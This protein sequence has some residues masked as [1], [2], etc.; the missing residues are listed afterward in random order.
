MGLRLS[1][2]AGPF[3][4]EDGVPTG[5][6]YPR[7]VHKRALTCRILAG[8][9]LLGAAADAR[10]TGALMVIPAAVAAATALLWCARRE[11]DRPR[12]PPRWA[13]A[14]AVA[15]TSLAATAAHPVT[16]GDR[17]GLWWLVET[18]GLVALLSLTARR[19]ASWRGPT[20]QALLLTALTALPIRLGLAL[21]PPSD[22]GELTAVCLVSGLLGLAAS[23]AGGHLR[24]LDRRRTR[25]VADARRAQR[26]ALAR[27]LHDFVAHEVSGILVQAQAGLVV[28]ERDPAQA[29]AALRRIEEA[30]RR[31]MSS[32]DDAV[33]MLRDEAD[34]SVPHGRGLT[35]VTDAVRRYEER[36]PAQVALTVA[37]AVHDDPQPPPE[38]WALAHRVVV[39]ALTNVTRHAPDARRIEVEL[40]RTDGEFT[41]AVTND[42]GDGTSQL[43]SAAR[44]GGGHGVRGLRERARALGGTLTAGRVADG[45]WRLRATLPVARHAAS[46]PAVPAVPEDF[47]G[48]EARER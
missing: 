10:A 12:V 30:G 33:A 1:A 29:L 3:L 39:E 43:P 37:A 23:A 26:L 27:D 44:S 42:A 34:H 40:A 20:A 46:L 18:A 45:R 17:A 21:E 15:V 38:V 8:A 24:R 31:A 6:G 36:S 22:A 14:S 11:K 41:V 5:S 7:E 47:E 48:L 9:V 16:A 19:Q 25:A 35:L 28:G 2:E 13:L 32:L 4:G